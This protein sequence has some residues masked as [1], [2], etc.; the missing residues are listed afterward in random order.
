MLSGRRAKPGAE[1]KLLHRCDELLR[2]FQ[3]QLDGFVSWENPR[4]IAFA[5]I[6]KGGLESALVVGRQIPWLHNVFTERGDHAG[7][8]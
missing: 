7:M 8:L 1:Q 3:A 2:L 6:L 4:V 5:P